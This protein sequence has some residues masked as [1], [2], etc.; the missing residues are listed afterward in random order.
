MG[1]WINCLVTD[2][3]PAERLLAMD[4]ATDRKTRLEEKDVKMAIEESK[5]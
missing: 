4:S 1:H 5:A 2:T 3:Y